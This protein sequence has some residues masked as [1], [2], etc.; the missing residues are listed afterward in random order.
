MATNKINKTEINL[1]DNFLH[2][3]STN[4][5]KFNKLIYLILILAGIVGY[6]SIDRFNLFSSSALPESPVEEKVEQAKALTVSTIEIE[7]VNSYQVSRSYTGEIAAIRTSELGFSRG[8]ELIQILVSEGDR[9]SQGTIVALLDTREL[10]AQRQQLVA[11]KVGENARLAELKT[12]ARIE[13]IDAARADV[14]DLEQQ[15]KLQQ[16][17]RERREFLYNEGAI[18]R[19]ELDE[20]SFGEGAL[21]ARL[22]KAKSVLAELN[23]GTR[24]EKIAAQQAVIDRLNARIAEIDVTIDRSSIKAPFNGIVAE[25]FLDEGTVVNTAQSVIRLLENTTPEARIGIPSNTIQQLRVGSYRDLKI[26]DRIYRGQITSIL[27][28]I[29]TDT[30][31]QIVV[32]QLERSAITQINPNQIVTLN[33]SQ[34]IPTDGYWLP[35]TALT[36]GIKGLWS[37]YVVIQ[38]QEGED[39]YRVEQKAVE[40]I[41]QENDRVFVRGTLRSGDLVVTDGIHRLVPK[42]VVRIIDN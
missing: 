34:S 7:P 33:L 27:P 18:S 9:I 14:R 24:P 41:N 32:F 6:I 16:K 1:E 20:F 4:K 28:E 3:S 35:M 29:D 2:T 37:C 11:E 23:N 22:A 19:E 39:L 31:T 26:G 17:Q 40:V 15:L 12:G 13:D 10:K 42:Q 38:E 36:Q 5:N 8:G 30:R 21:N 25:R